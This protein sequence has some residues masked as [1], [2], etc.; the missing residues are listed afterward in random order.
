MARRT[1]DAANVDPDLPGF[2]L[3]PLDSVRTQ[4]G[5]LEAKPG[6]LRKFY[7]SQEAE[8]R[9]GKAAVVAFLNGVD[10][11]YIA[12][13]W[14]GVAMYA[15]AMRRDLTAREKQII[16]SM[17][18]HCAEWGFRDGA[19]CAKQQKVA[20]LKKGKQ[21]REVKTNT[22]HDAIRAAFAKAARAGEV[23]VSAICKECGVSRA[24]YYR[25]TGGKASSSTRR[26]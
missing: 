22:S 16:F 11:D 14:R 8:K 13:A 24:T 15:K 9:L 3:P 25:A 4:S 20:S 10:E 21:S 6:A 5:F 2:N 23:D 26:R 12:M 19:R 7:R 1:S 18:Y 17:A